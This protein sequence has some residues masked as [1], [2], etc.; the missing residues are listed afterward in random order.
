M[1]IIHSL[2]IILSGVCEEI[3]YSSSLILNSISLITIQWDK[4]GSE[5]IRMDD[6]YGDKFNYTC[7][8]D[9]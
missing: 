1:R 7:D 2:F 6:K 9:Y 5:W 4:N 3:S 8:N